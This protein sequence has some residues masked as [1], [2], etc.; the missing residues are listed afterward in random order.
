VFYRSG[1]AIFGK[2]GRITSEKVVLQLV[3]SM[4][5]RYTVWL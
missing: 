1:N 3:M 2:I 5:T 4:Y